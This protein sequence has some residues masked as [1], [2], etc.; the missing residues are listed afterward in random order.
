M[1]K[2]GHIPTAEEILCAL[3]EKEIDTV[4]RK[5]SMQEYHSS[6]EFQRQGK[7]LSEQ[8]QQSKFEANMRFRQAQ[9]QNPIK[10]RPRRK[11]GRKVR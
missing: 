11:R 2:R 5:V 4:P 9:A 6:P 7:T 10:G 3:P 8:V 1:D